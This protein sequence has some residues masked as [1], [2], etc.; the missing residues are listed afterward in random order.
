LRVLLNC[1]IP[2]GFTGRR[3]AFDDFQPDIPIDTGTCGAL[4]G[5]LVVKAMVLATSCLEYEFSG[6]GSPHR[7]MTEMKLP[8]GLDL[9]PRRDS[10]KLTHPDRARQRKRGQREKLPQRVLP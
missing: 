8:S 6:N 10:K 5:N 2:L 1:P 4:D 9:L 7:I 3:S